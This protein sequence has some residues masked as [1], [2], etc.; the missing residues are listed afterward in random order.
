M[1]LWQLPVGI[2]LALVSGIINNLGNV[3]QKQAVNSE[4]VKLQQ[5]QKQRSIEEG[6]S[7]SPTEREDCSSNTPSQPA[8]FGMK[9]L[10]RNKTWLLGFL[11]QTVIATGLF[12]VTQSLIGPTLTPALGS[13]GLIVLGFSA[14]FFKE[15]LTWDEYLGLFFIIASVFLLSF[16][17]LSIDQSRTDFLDR[18]ML[19]RVSIYSGFILLLGLACKLWAFRKD[20]WEGTC[21]ALLSGLLVAFSNFWVAPFVAVGEKIITNKFSD[22]PTLHDHPVASSVLFWLASTF[23]VIWSNAQAIY[24]RQL[25]FKVGKATTMIPITHI[26]SYL[27]PPVIYAL[28]FDLTPPEVYSMPMMCIGIVLLVIA[29]FIFGKREAS[30]QLSKKDAPLVDKSVEIREAPLQ[31]CDAEKEISVIDDVSRNTD[32][33]LK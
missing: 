32:T 22:T 15:K 9:V 17:G 26:P 2:V 18:G 1:I 11:L 12:V 30:L 13:I 7:A 3:F 29:S 27:S 33:T 16:S 4:L 10:F 8:S 21:L 25:A 20:R 24:E 28:C 14:I 6:K 19:I 31:C 5:A 23:L